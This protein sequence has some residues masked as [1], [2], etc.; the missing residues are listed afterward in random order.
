[1]ISSTISGNATDITSQVGEARWHNNQQPICC[2]PKTNRKNANEKGNWYFWLIDFRQVC[3]RLWVGMQVMCVICAQ[4]RCSDGCEL[5]GAD[6]VCRWMWCR[7]ISMRMKGVCRNGVN[8]MVIDFNV[9]EPQKWWD[10][11]REHAEDE[12]GHRQSWVSQYWFCLA[13]F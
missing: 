10:I 1:M 9:S 4:A 3:V 5:G 11:L 12:E 2:L 8:H 6:G 13:W 7:L